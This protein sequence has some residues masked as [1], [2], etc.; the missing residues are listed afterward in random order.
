M[1]TTNTLTCFE[2]FFF[3]KKTNIPSLKENAYNLVNFT[4]Y[5][6]IAY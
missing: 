1:H 5:I 4:N 3:K 2:Q 6:Q